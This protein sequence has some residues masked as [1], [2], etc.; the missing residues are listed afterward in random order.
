LKKELAILVI[1]CDKYEDAWVPFFSLLKVFWHDC[2]YR[3]YLG[4]NK[5]DFS[6]PGVTVLKSGED[7]SWADNVRKFLDQIEEEYVLT[8]LEDFYLSDYVDTAKIEEAFKLA[9]NENADVIS[10]ILPKK[11]LSYKDKPGIY[12]INPESE[13]C[14]NTSIAIR[15]KEMF[16]ILLKPGYSAWDFEIKNSKSMNKIGKFPG[17]FLTYEEEYFKVLNGMWRGKWVNSTVKF[18]RKLG[19]EIDTSRRPL[20]NL[21]DTAWDYCKLKGRKMLSPK[22]RKIIKSMLIKLGYSHRFVSQD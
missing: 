14:I 21:R 4:V 19:I 3:I 13:Y 18:C 7:V 12:Y 2:P 10:M 16:R 5:L 11:G 1:S 17:L 9:V 15:K 6:Y 20:M 8:F 22:I